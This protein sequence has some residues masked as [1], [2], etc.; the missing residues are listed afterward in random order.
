M[1]VR[2]IK[3]TEEK[4]I[5]DYVERITWEG[6]DS[7][8]SRT[9]SITVA[10]DYYN[11]VWLDISPGDLLW[12]RENGDLFIGVVTNRP[13][14]GETGTV[15]HTAK[16]FMHYLL[17][18]TGSYNFKKTMPEKVAKKVCADLMIQTGNLYE[19]K[20]YLPKLLFESESYYNMIVKAYNS[21]AKKMSAK[22]PP[23]FMPVM[24]MMKLS[25]IIKGQRSGIVLDG[26]NDI[27]SAEYE[28]HSDN[29]VTRVKILNSS[30]KVTGTVENEEDIKR[31]GVYQSTY[32]KTGKENAKTAAKQLLT[33]LTKEAKVKAVGYIQCR[34][35]YSVEVKDRASGLVGTFY[36]AND[37][38]TWENGIHTMDLNLKYT[39]EME[40]V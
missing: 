7:Q 21:A 23:A 26:D 8:T 4:N 19:T 27:M 2:W 1:E 36:I 31:F 30:G 10:Y 13:R 14:K 18:S 5:T 35:G 11:G 17:R 22:Y 9:V 29:M 39:N 16:D 32:K 6:S 24:D 28:E 12:L 25:V 34:A 40:D 3:G 20:K 15:S 38:H 33:G 37:S